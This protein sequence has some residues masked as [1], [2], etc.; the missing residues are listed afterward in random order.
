MFEAWA[1]RTMV[2]GDLFAVQLSL[3][4]LVHP[5]THLK[6]EY[7]SV[8]KRDGWGSRFPGG[9]KIGQPAAVNWNGGIDY[10]LPTSRK[11]GEK[12]GTPARDVNRIKTPNVSRASRVS[13]NLQAGYS[14]RLASQSPCMSPRRGTNT[15][16]LPRM[17]SPST[18]PR[19]VSRLR[20]LV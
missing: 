8:E 20:V 1:P 2:T 10:V 17:L 9:A 12:W 3:R 11:R 15:P 13:S 18:W 14:E 4:L 6:H 16:H 19:K 5:H 7:P